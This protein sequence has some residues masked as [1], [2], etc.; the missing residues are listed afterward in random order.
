MMMPRPAMSSTRVN[1]SDAEA[2]SQGRTMVR[3]PYRVVSLVA[4]SSR[5][6]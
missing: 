2:M 3:I 4:R 1:R 6:S 5:T